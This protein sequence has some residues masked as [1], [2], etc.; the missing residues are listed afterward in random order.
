MP[1]D[2]LRDLCLGLP[3]AT[4]SFPFDADTLVFKVAGKVF[5][6]TSLERVPPTVNL[7]CDPERAVDLRERFEAVEPG[8][9]MNKRHWNTV[10]LRGDASAQEIRQWVRESYDLVVAGMPARLRAEIG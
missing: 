4:E 7:K 6:L 9:H 2:E 5:A 3:G 1:L 8:W 10:A